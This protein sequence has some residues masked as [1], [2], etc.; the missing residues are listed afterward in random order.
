METTL[1]KRIVQ[2]RKRLAMT[3]DQLAEQLGVTAQA[4]SKWENDQSCPDIGMLPNLAEIFGISTD[5]LLGRTSPAPTYIDT[6]ESPEENRDTKADVGNWEFEY[7]SGRKG[8][9]C[10]ALTVLTVGV[11]YLLSKILE[12]DASLWEILW[13]TLPLI[14]GL[15]GIWPNFAFLRIGC[16]ILGAY[17]LSS[18][19]GLLPSDFGSELIWPFIIIILGLGLLVDAFKKPQKAKVKFKGKTN[20]R[21]ERLNMEKDS[22]DYFAS[23]GESTQYIHLPCMQSGSVSTRFGE[24]KLDFSGVTALAEDCTLNVNCAFGE[25][26]L[27]IPS[28]YEVRPNSANFFSGTTIKGAPNPEPEGVIRLS[29]SAS[30]GEITIRYI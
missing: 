11:L 23:F 3:Q 2:N 24:Y 14:Y 10:F 22:F 6:A 9:L 19:L 13:P 20:Q 15:F 18:N 17:C 26:V 25:L 5:A 1:G 12:W 4:V 28:R 7:E 30:F 29:T 21:R 8:L 16:A 27:L